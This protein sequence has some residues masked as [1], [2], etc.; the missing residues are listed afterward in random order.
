MGD[1]TIDSSRFDYNIYRRTYKTDDIHISTLFDT[2]SKLRFL[3]AFKSEDNIDML[4]RM[5]MQR[6]DLYDKKMLYIMKIDVINFITSWTNLGKFDEKVLIKSSSISNQV[7][8]YNKLFVE[9]FEYDFRK[10]YGYKYDSNPFFEVINGKKREDFRPEDYASLSAQQNRISSQ[11]ESVNSTRDTI[12]FYEKSL[13]RRHYDTKGMDTNTVHGSDRSAL[14]Y[15]DVAKY[16]KE[17]DTIVDRTSN[18]ETAVEKESLNY[19]RYPKKDLQ[20]LIN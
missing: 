6:L 11:R 12:K 15:T 3:E 8:Y 20:A 4:S 1:S 9:V 18:A 10:K 7:A 17:L 5:I 2:G 13:Y 14:V 19:A 16:Y